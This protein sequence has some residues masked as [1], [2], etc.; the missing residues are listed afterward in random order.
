ML[1]GSDVD[2]GN[3]GRVSICFGSCRQAGD[4]MGSGGQAGAGV[5][6][7][8]WAAGGVV[9]SGRAGGR[10]DCPFNYSAVS[11][12][13]VWT[14]IG[15]LQLPFVLVQVADLIA[16]AQR[17]KRADV[18]RKLGVV[19]QFA[20]GSEDGVALGGS[21]EFDFDK[22]GTGS[23]VDG[24]AAF[25]VIVALHLSHSVDFYEIT[26]LDADSLERTY[27]HRHLPGRHAPLTGCDSHVTELPR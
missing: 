11:A 17:N 21:G 9:G 2:I 16:L 6:L 10:L 3:N 23:V 19:F 27:P 24:S 14:S 13:E 20:G 22:T 25:A 4:G 26:I 15:F 7:D 8:R 18:Y 5:A 12:D 1:S